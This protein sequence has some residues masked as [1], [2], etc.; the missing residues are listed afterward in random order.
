[1]IRKSRLAGALI[2]ACL[3][4]QA[5][6]ALASQLVVVEARGANLRPG[7]RIDGN[8]PVQLKEGEKIVLIAPDGRAIT[9]RGVYRGPAAQGGGGGTQNAS[10]AL[11]ALISTRRDRASAVGAVRS[12]SGAADLPDPWLID[13]TRAGERCIREGDSPT[14]WRP[15]GAGS[16][17]F[18]V[19]P[20]DRSW[21][22]DFVWK[23]GA[24]TMQAP[25]LGK[26]DGARSF[27][28]TVAD[29]EYAV[30]LN[31][32]PRDLTDPMILTSWMLQKACFQQADA[33]LRAIQSDLAHAG[34]AA[35]KP[36]QPSEDKQ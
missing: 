19:Y 18:T 20:I 8:T 22:A 13:I 25:E 23:D 33:Y 26:L 3:A 17:P 36:A 35:G 6:N 4:L 27:I 34:A 16:Q 1:M 14:W 2:G 31:V 5:G 10:I 11:A 21:K 9:L 24:T 30:R 15:T 28:V 29:Q 32:I 12:G 7:M